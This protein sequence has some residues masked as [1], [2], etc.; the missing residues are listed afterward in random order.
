MKVEVL[1]STRHAKNKL[2]HFQCNLKVVWEKEC[3]GKHFS[4]M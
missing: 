4:T 1:L 2:I 3:I